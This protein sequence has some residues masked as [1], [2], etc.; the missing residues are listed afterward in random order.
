MSLHRRGSGTVLLM[1]TVVPHSTSADIAAFTLVDGHHEANIA[2]YAGCELAGTVQA[3]A[4]DKAAAGEAH[5]G[6]PV[7]AVC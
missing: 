2:L 7:Q 3:Q 1:Q 6:V 4:A 5:S